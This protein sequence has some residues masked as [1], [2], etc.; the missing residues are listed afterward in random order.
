VQRAL[1]CAAALWR[2]AQSI[3]ECMAW[4]TECI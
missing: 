2:T 1:C 4:P 3:K